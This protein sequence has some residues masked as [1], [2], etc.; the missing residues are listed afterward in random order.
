M[1]KIRILLV[2]LLLFSTK[3]QA[4]E[5]P[6]T[7]VRAVWLTTNYGLDWPRNRSSVELQKRE[8]IAILDGLQ[9]HNFNTVMFQVRARNEVFYKS[10]IEPMSSLIARNRVGESPFDP[11]AFALE[12]SHKRGMSLHAW[13]VVYPVGTDRHVQSLGANSITRKRPDLVRNFN[14]EWVLDPGNPETDVYLLSLIREIVEN[15]DVDGI[16][17]DY[18]RYPDNRGL[19]PDRETH[20]RFGNGQNH[21]DWR[22]NNITRFV[23][24]T[25][26]WV[27]SVKPWVQVSSSPLGRYSALPCGTGHGWTA[28]ETVFQDAG[29]WLRIGKHDA[30]YPMMYH[31]DELFFPFVTQWIETSNNRI[32]VPGLGAY[33]MNDNADWS[34]QDI[35]EQ[36]DY[37]RL[38]DT[39]G[40]I[41]FRAEDILSNSKEILDSIREYYTYPAKL[42]P[43][44]WLHDTIPA[45]PF[46]LRAERMNDTVFRLSWRS[47]YENERV[48]YNIYRSE[49]DDFCTDTGANLLAVGVREPFFEY[50]PQKDDR[51]FYYF[52]TVSDSFN[53]ESERSEVAFFF[54]SEI[55]K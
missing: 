17:F 14:G 37:T 33:R 40:Q 45:F 53:N 51:A 15:Y 21:D 38:R 13:F 55:E 10:Q 36:I 11:L 20:R 35:L 19:F 43:M 50:N 42:P 23:T 2:V 22:R 3:L 4:N 7:E 18:I 12:E 5:T 26:D 30:V 24:T 52:I 27:K 47:L 44:T 29:H 48:T 9:H 1:Y 46:D 49:T 54:H 8:L 6:A 32:V 41:F 16:H 34:R 39:H 31:K 28:R 25:Y